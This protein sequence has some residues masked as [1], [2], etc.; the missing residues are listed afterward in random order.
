MGYKGLSLRLI[1]SV[2]KDWGCECIFFFNYNRINMGL[3]NDMVKA[4][5]EALFGKARTAS[6]SEKVAGMTAYKRELTVVEELCEALNQMGGRYVLPFT[7]KNSSGKRTS[8]HLIFVSKHPLGYGIMKTIMA[9]ESSTHEQGV[10]TFEYNPADKAQPFLF[11]YARP[12]DDLEHMLLDTFAGK[13]ITVQEIFESHNVGRPYI[14]PNY[15]EV[16]RKMYDMGTITAT[17]E[18]DKPIR[19]NSFPE[20]IRVTFPKKRRG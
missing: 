18:G 5:M 11:E 12:L 14:M 15:K 4:H 9:K 16:L 3:S 19:R 13:T 10:A 2:L 20:D 6:L 8:H 1:N 7:F 17:R